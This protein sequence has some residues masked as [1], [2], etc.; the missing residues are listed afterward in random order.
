MKLPR[1]KDFLLLG[2]L[3]AVG[4]AA[5]L[6]ILAGGSNTVSSHSIDASQSV[7]CSTATPAPPASPTP[8]C[9]ESYLELIVDKPMVLVGE[10]FTLTIIYH[11][12]GLPYTRVGLDP[13][14]LTEFDPPIT[15]WPCKYDCD[16]FTL[17]AVGLGRV[18]IWA[19]A[20]GEVYC[21]GW[22]W[23]GGSSKTPAVVFIVEE[24]WTTHLPLLMR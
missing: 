19:G 6:I 2:G 8:F 4:A 1:K 22:L 17:R 5:V 15:E 20:T 13:E 12:L 9:P 16:A 14:G 10:P 23:G 3:L 18:E 11:N 21:N 7:A 24:K